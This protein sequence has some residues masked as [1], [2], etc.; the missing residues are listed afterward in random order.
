MMKK[1]ASETDQ[2][3]LAKQTMARASTLVTNYSRGL[4]ARFHF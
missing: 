4:R 3:F 2:L 1:A